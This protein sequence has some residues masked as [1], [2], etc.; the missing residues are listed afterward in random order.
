MRQ[1]VGSVRDDSTVRDLLVSV[2]PPV[3]RAAA[4]ELDAAELAMMEADDERTQLRY[5]HALT[6]WADAGGY[7]AEGRWDVCT[8]EAVGLPFETARWREGRTPSRG[9]P[10]RLVLEALP[11]GPGEVLLLDEPDNYLDVPGKRWL[12]QRI[13]DSQKTILYVSHDREL[14]AQTATHVVTVELGAAGNTVWVHGGG[15]ASYHEA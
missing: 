4:A 12:E 2:A 13:A 1:F 11:R 10:K 9:A 6:E 15:F 8:I 7:D 5:A 3:I 14:L